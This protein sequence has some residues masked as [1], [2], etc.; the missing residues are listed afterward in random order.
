MAGEQAEVLVRHLGMHKDAAVSV[1]SKWVGGGHGGR[2][3]DVSAP[4]VP[5]I[6]EVQKSDGMIRMA[7]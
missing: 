6:R 3:R 4:V 2:E 7:A 1:P 5:A